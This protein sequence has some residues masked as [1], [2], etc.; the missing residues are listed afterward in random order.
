MTDDADTFVNRR[1]VNVVHELAT[2][3]PWFCRL[4]A[5]RPVGLHGHLPSLGSCARRVGAVFR[6][7]RSTYVAPRQLDVDAPSSSAVCA[8]LHRF[9]FSLTIERR[10]MRRVAHRV[11]PRE[12]GCS[13]HKKQLLPV[14]VVLATP[15]KKRNQKQHALTGNTSPSAAG[16][17]PRS[18]RQRV[19][20]ANDDDLEPR[21]RVGGH[22]YPP[23]GDIL[24][25]VPDWHNRPVIMQLSFCALAGC[26]LR[27]SDYTPVEGVNV[28]WALEGGLHTRATM[29]CSSPATGSLG[30][31]SKEF[32]HRPLP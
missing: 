1:D 3:V 21:Q 32:S 6:G 12:S 13:I 9:S 11:R 19:D 17:P 8:R 18:V 5:R 15:R 7:S 22:P 16:S 20:L 24:T 14:L 29:V 4:C 30:G 27:P 31:P 23:E 10:F 2:V 26:N 25:M 28:V